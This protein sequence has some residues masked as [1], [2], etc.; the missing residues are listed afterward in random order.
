MRVTGVD[1]QPYAEGGPPLDELAYE[2]ALRA[3]DQQAGVLDEL[4]QR[5]STLIAVTALVATFL[6][7]ESLNARPADQGPGVVLILA[8]ATLLLG[9]GAC[10]AVLRPTT[11]RK[12]NETNGNEARSDT[13]HPDEVEDDGERPKPGQK[14]P[15]NVLAL[16]F[17]LNVEVMLD[18]AEERGTPFPDTARMAAARTLQ[19]ARDE[20]ATIIDEKQ[21]VFTLACAL[22]LA[23]AA[24]WITFIA[25]GKG[26]I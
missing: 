14:H 18:R 22:L 1:T 19:L 10:L 20:N 12:R 25:L 24:S 17:A 8:L 26:V 21:R 13:K 6:G 11:T 9:V 15:E 3:L 2:Q 16:A 5:T 4:R 7:A 23:Q